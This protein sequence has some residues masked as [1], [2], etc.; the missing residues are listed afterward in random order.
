MEVIEFL[1][2]A[3]EDP[4]VGEAERL[5]F[6]RDV[7]VVER[8]LAGIDEECHIIIGQLVDIVVSERLLGHQ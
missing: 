7:G 1:R 5:P 2:P 6:C 3:T 8:V 4:I